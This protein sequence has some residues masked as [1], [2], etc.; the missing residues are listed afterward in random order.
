MWILFCYDSEVKLLFIRHGQTELNQQNRLHKRDDEIG[1]D[2]IGRD[3]ACKVAV[4]CKSQKVEAIY[5]STERRAIETAEI[6]GQDLGL[7]PTPLKA[8]RERDWGDWTDRGWDD[9]KAELE[10]MNLEA[11]Y[12][13]VPPNGE[14]WEQMDKRLRKTLNVINSTRKDVVAI[15]MHGGALRA[16]MP[17][18]KKVPKEHAFEFDFSNASITFFDYQ[19]GN[20]KMIAENLTSHLK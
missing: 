12:K 9:I 10:T 2:D 11:R 5:S 7:R 14:S 16:L 19:Y 8:L 1:L 6:I 20:Y 17:I 15:V 4:E 3:Q 18:L 13:F